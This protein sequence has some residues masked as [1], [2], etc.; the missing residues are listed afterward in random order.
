MKKNIT[1]KIHG[2]AAGVRIYVAARNGTVTI[3][4]L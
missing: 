4:S 3:G 2:K 1:V